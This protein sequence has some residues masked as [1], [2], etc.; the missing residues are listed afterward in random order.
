MEMLFNVYRAPLLDERR[1]ITFI[2][3]DIRDIAGWN[4][5]EISGPCFTNEWDA[6]KP[7]ADQSCSFLNRT[8][9]HS[10]FMSE[11]LITSSSRFCL[12]RST[13]RQSMISP[14]DV[15]IG[16]YALSKRVPKSHRKRSIAM[17][18]FMYPLKRVLISLS[19]SSTIRFTQ[20]RLKLMRFIASLLRTHKRFLTMMKNDRSL[21]G[22]IRVVFTIFKPA[23]DCTN[24]ASCLFYSDLGTIHD[25]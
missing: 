9:M 19:V 20:V 21:E 10:V 22:C 7:D 12:F 15:G 5:R 3:G 17:S 4:K 2:T 11:S 24:F 6:I 13:I 8:S 25:P 23:V 18:Y 16:F 14:R 1:K